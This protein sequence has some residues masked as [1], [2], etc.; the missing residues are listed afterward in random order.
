MEMKHPKEEQSQ[1]RSM[2]GSIVCYVL[3][4]GYC[5]PVNIVFRVAWFSYFF[6]CPC[7]AKDQLNSSEDA[8]DECKETRFRVWFTASACNL[9]WIL[10]P[11]LWRLLNYDWGK[12]LK[13][14]ELHLFLVEVHIT[15]YSL[16]FT[17]ALVLAISF[18]LCTLQEICKKSLETRLQTFLQ[19]FRY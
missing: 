19:I 2:L 3:G 5:L 13:Q 15:L 12:V 6:G 7:I 11:L 10:V 17:T 4:F 9:C 14:P 16:G 18:A 8:A 1:T